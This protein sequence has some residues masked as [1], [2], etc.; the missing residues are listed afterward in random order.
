MRFKARRHRTARR[1]VWRTAAKEMVAEQL[2]CN[3]TMATR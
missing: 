2:G 1:L 3:Q